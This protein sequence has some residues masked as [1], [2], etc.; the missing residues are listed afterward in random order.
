ME[1]RTSWAF[2]SVENPVSVADFHATVLHQLGFDYKQLYYEL[3]GQR[4]RLTAN[5]P[6]R[7]VKEV[8]A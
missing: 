3:D 1:P 4:E 2:R 5:F 7:V 6:A 8:I